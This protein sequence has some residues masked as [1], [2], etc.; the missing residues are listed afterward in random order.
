MVYTMLTTH[1]C[2][3]YLIC[4]ASYLFVIL[5]FEFSLVCLHMYRNQRCETIIEIK[6]S[7]YRFLASCLTLEECL[8]VHTFDCSYSHLYTI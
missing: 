4:S 1:G 8:V 6:M 2:N 5:V 7:L 3:Q